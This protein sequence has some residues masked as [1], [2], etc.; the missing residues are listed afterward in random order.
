M[1]FIFFKYFLMKK[2]KKTDMA[3]DNEKEGKKPRGLP[4]PLT[5]PSVSKHRCT[6][7][8]TNTNTP[9]FQHFNP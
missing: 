8:N 7:T 3:V 2:Q 6:N 5:T 1:F 4:Y 9:T